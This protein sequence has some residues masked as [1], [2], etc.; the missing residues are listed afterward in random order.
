MGCDLY[1]Y[2]EQQNDHGTWEHKRWEPL[3]QYEDGPFTARIYRV[4]GFLADVRNYSQVP[5][6]AKVRGLPDDVS[7][8]VRAEDGKWGGY[9]HSHSHLTVDEL[10]AFDYDQSFE[11]RRVTR[12]NNGGRTAVS[13][14]GEMTTFREFFGADFFRDLDVLVVMNRDRPTRVVFWFDN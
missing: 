9:G 10:A 11:D 8:E 6:I 5:P 1:S 7:A 3:E 14:G 4:Y 2:V 12:G 13:G